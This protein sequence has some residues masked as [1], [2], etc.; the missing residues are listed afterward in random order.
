M[1]HSTKKKKKKKGNGTN[2]KHLSA[3]RALVGGPSSPGTP[4]PSAQVLP[5]A[6]AETANS[7]EWE[8]RHLLQDACRELLMKLFH[9]LLP[10]S[11]KRGRTAECFVE[12]F[13]G[14]WGQTASPMLAPTEPNTQK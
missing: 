1:F 12:P 8:Q 9:N 4:T 14:S 10:H 13:K 11:E 5:H 6:D 3:L 2:T 7:G